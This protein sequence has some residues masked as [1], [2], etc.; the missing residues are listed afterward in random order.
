[1]DTLQLLVLLNHIILYLGGFL[2]GAS[3]GSFLGCAIYRVPRHISLIASR[4]ACPSC[5]HVL[6]ASELIPVAS[7]LMQ[8]GKCRECGVKLSPAYVWAET[9]CGLLGIGITWL[10]LAF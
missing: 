9:L 4:S 8:G 5:G 1:M 7:Y 3:F 6:T 2:A 10:I